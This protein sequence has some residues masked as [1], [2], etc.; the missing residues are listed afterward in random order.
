MSEVFDMQYSG[1]HGEKLRL[2]L[3]LWTK[4]VRQKGGNLF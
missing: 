3:I 2:F 4:F 1:I